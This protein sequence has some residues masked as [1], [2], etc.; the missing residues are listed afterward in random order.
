MLQATKAR[1]P[2]G[3][4]PGNGGQTL[5]EDAVRAAGPPAAQAAH[6]HLDLYAAALPG[7]VRQPARIA[8]VPPR[9]RVTAA[10]ADRGRDARP[11]QDGDVVR[12]G[13]HLIDDE[14]GR[15]EGQKALGHGTA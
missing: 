2:L 14:I 4:R 3:I 11:A 13:Q 12:G 8:A 9:R 5:G 15:H 10:G 6:L 1:R 7:Q